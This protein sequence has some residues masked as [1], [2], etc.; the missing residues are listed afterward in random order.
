VAI[1]YNQVRTD[2]RPS[3]RR[4]LATPPTSCPAARPQRCGANRHATAVG[5]K[6]ASVRVGQLA[7]R[8]GFP[9]AGATQSSSSAAASFAPVISTDTLPVLTPPRP[10]TDRPRSDPVPSRCHNYQALSE[11][12]AEMADAVEE[13]AVTLINVFAVEPENQQALV[14]CSFRRPTK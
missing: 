13:E 4:D 10:E 9:G 2:D 8:L 11:R 7:K 3:S 6:L 5:S 12:E 1:R 14:A